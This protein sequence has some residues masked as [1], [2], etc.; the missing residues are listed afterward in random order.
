M[1][2]AVL[3]KRFEKNAFKV[4]SWVWETPVTSQEKREIKQKKQFS[5]MKPF[6]S[7]SRK[8]KLILSK[9]KTIFW[10]MYTGV[11]P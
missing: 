8:F 7:Y 1:V 5:S 2:R 9:K 4:L 6:A 3:K 11:A 10:K